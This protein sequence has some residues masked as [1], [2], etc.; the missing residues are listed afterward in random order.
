[1]SVKGHLYNAVLALIFSVLIWGAVGAQLSEEKTIG[2]DFLLRVPSHVTIEHEGVPATGSLRVPMEVTVRGPRE[3]IA[4]LTKR[5]IVGQRD[6]SQDVEQLQEHLAR[7]TTSVAVRPG[8]DISVPQGLEVVG[9]RPSELTLTFSS[10]QRR[11]VEVEPAVQG[12]PAEGFAVGAVK[13][14]PSVVRVRGPEAVL[15]QSVGLPYRTEPISL[16]G[17]RQSF[18][19]RKAVQCPPGVTTDTLVEVDVEIVPVPVPVPVRFPIQI[20]RD[21]PARSTRARELT[22]TP[23]V[24]ELPRGQEDWTWEIELEGPRDVLA[25]LRARLA[26]EIAQPGS[27]PDL[28]IAFVRASEFPQED[29]AD[30]A[31]DIEVVGLPPGVSYH[32]REKFPI[33]VRRE[34]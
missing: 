3:L 27:V 19:V 12:S 23:F 17:K 29:D 33:R 34:E 8:E 26:T 31:L 25:D 7:G 22:P 15:E 4:R 18:V 6:F 10:V 5:E 2:I 13:I 11:D 32:G 30:D 9:T 21:T 16:T 20:L 28:P 24:V 14:R 1:M